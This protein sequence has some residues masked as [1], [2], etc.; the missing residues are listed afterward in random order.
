MGFGVDTVVELSPEEWDCLYQKEFFYI[1]RK[2]SNKILEAL[3]TFRQEMGKVVEVRKNELP[4]WFSNSAKISKGENFKELPY[5]VLDYPKANVS[6]GFI[7]F[8]TMVWW[9]NYIQY[10]IHAS[11]SF[12]PYLQQKQ[13]TL[14]DLGFSCFVGEDQW[15]HAFTEE[16]Y[17]REFTERF[18]SDKPSFIKVSLS[19]PMDK[20][21][22][23]SKTLL[24]Y[25]EKVIR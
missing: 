5:F 15:D 21:P 23:L 4:P 22:A 25:F 10:I 12:L 17:S 20:L 16:N 19:V 9:G 6:D 11:G 8:R 2:V 14:S 3:N 24:P 13:K 18:N 7:L 1:K